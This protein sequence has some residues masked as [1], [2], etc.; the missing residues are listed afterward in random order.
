MRCTRFAFLF[1]LALIVPFA[2]AQQP[3]TSANQGPAILQKA[4]LALVP[5]TSIND[6]TL[7]GTARRIAGSD[8]ESGTVVIK[9]VAGT[10]TRIDLTL[11]SGPRSEIRNTSSVPFAGSWSGPDDVTH[12]AS[13]HNIL[14]DPG[15]APALTIASLLS[16]QNSV[17][18]YF[19]PET[20]NGQSVIHVSA[21]QQFPGTSGDTASLMQHLTQTD[22]YF[23]A[24]TLLPAAIAFSTHPDNNANLDIP[25]ELDFYNYTAVNGAQIPFR[26]QKYINN[27]L[28]LDFQV[29]SVVLNS[30]LSAATFSVGAGF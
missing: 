7:S 22:L 16:A 25:I 13:Y 21:S 2:F 23:D 17:I 15:W 18:T 28:A 12:S 5:S 26:I 24:T 9:A 8:D 19:G 14:V 1:I 27:I 4:L 6:I 29:N 10:G 3:S 30:G 20:R 11:P